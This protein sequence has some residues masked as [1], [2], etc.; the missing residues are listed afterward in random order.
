[1]SHFRKCQKREEGQRE[2]ARKQAAPPPPPPHPLPPPTYF[3]QG[4]IRNWQ[5]SPNILALSTV[6]ELTE[7][8]TAKGLL[9]T[10]G[11]QCLGFFCKRTKLTDKHCLL[12]TY[13]LRKL[14]GSIPFVKSFLKCMK[15]L[16][17][18]APCRC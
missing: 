16:V 3:T 13:S 6:N 12:L 11:C 14:G 4:S 17:A 8:V 10:L 15:A 9:S 7:T 1:M 5:F 2:E 18:K